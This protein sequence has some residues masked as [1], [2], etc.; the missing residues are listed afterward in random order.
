[1]YKRRLGRD[2]LDRSAKPGARTN[3]TYPTTSSLPPGTT[4]VAEMVIALVFI[5]LGVVIMLF[6]GLGVGRPVSP[7]WHCVPILAARGCCCFLSCPPVG[8]AV[9]CGSRGRSLVALE[10]WRGKPLRP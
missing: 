7:L 3:R 10:A 5:I 1:M 4:G 8:D 6:L 2:Q 9:G